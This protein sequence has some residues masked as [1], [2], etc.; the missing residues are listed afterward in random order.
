MEGVGRHLLSG[1][2]PSDAGTGATKPSYEAEEHCVMV[3]YVYDF[4]EGGRDLAGLLGGK[5]AN[6]AEMTRLGLPVP[7]GFRHLHRGH[8]TGCW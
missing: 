6:L 3:R 5:G 2:H 1:R 7:P 8:A 4:Q